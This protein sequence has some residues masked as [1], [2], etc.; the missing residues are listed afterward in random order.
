ML[1]LHL[2]PKPPAPIR[3]I[4]ERTQEQVALHTD[5]EFMK[6]YATFFVIF[7]SLAYL[8]NA[9]RI[10]LQEDTVSDIMKLKQEICDTVPASALC[11]NPRPL[12]VMDEIAQAH[13]VPV[14]LLVG[15][16]FAES[17]LGTRFNR[18]Q[19][20]SYRNWSWLKWRKFPNWSVQYYSTDRS[21]PDSNWC[22]LYKFD[23]FEEATTALA[24]TISLG[25]R[26]CNNDTTCISYAYVGKPNV[27]EA[28]WIRNVSRFY[29]NPTT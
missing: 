29:P 6:A 23:S 11:I 13:Q 25:Y 28:S 20:S 27:A 19:C 21:K 16:Y 22:W 7:I 10:Q 26:T 18:P 9:M 8:F 14:R 15:I 17:T 5:I 2:L 4:Q 1:K 12:Y 24:L 3:S